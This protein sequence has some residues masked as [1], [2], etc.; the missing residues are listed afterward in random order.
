[1]SKT[2]TKKK[3]RK[4]RLKG[5]ETQ[6]PCVDCGKTKD[7][8]KAFKPRWAGCASHKTD[9][10][11]RYYQEGCDECA[12]LVNGNIRQ[13]RCIECDKTRPKKRSKKKTSDP[14]PTKVETPKAAVNVDPN[15]T[16]PPA[17]AVDLPEA[18]TKAVE[19]TPEAEPVTVEPQ[20]EASDESEDVTPE[21]TPAP[22]AKPK[23]A[24]MSDLLA[25]FGGL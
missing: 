10:G 9:K 23:I 1:M 15:P 14:K 18:E 6:K 24:S 11:R 8:F 2:D 25:Q 20:S 19:T 3:K 17:P 13:P 7:R 16:I 22:E 5:T 21:A 4:T 12:K